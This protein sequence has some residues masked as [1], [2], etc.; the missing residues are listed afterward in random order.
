MA[1]GLPCLSSIHPGATDDLI[2]D[3]ETGF[4]LD[5]ADS[6]AVADKIDWVPIEA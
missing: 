2:V 1:A 5:F 4:A 3:G 6:E